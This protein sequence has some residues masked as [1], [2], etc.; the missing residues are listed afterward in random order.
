MKIINRNILIILIVVMTFTTIFPF[1]VSKAATEKE[2]KEQLSKMQTD[3]L[4]EMATTDLMLK[5]GDFVTEYLTFLLKEEVTIH[6]IIFNKV[7]RLNANFFTNSKNPSKEDATNY[8]KITVNEWYRF[9]GKIAIMVYMVC[10]VYVGIKIMI[11]TASQKASAMEAIKKWTIGIALFYFFPYLMRY[12]C[13]LNEAIIGLVEKNFSGGN[14]MESQIGYISD[15]KKDE[16]EERSPE[17]VTNSTYFLTL[18]SEEATNAYLERFYNYKQ[19]G[20][21]MRIM[22]AYAGITGRIFYAILWYIFLYQT[23]LFTFI[24]FKRYLMI[25]F[26]IAIFPITLI[27]Y[28]VGNVAANKASAI[29]S[30]SKEF[31]TNVF[32][33]SIHAVIYGIISGVIIDQISYGLKNGSESSVNW[34]LMLIAINFIFTGEKIFKEIINAMGTTTITDMEEARQGL[35]K[36]RKGTMDRAKQIKGNIGRIGRGGR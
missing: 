1:S 24:Y 13:D 10:L 33:Q 34:F 8:I 20:D 7:S 27:E 11:G 17:Y 18:G 23:L 12:A 14:T 21:M 29:G 9:L 16:M 2:M 30:W 22:R 26:L 31:F 3:N 4:F 32:L 36:M 19:K 15:L 28:I 35:K 6:K 5:L 25:A